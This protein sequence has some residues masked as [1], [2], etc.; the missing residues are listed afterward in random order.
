MDLLDSLLAQKLLDVVSENFHSK[1]K[2]YKRGKAFVL[3]LG[4]GIGF[5]SF[6]SLEIV[7]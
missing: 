7:V 1:N 5:V 3:V 2:L 6:F 4:L